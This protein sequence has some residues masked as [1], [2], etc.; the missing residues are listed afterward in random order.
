MYS[1]QVDSNV[2]LDDN[3][4]FEDV[5]LVGATIGHTLDM[6]GS[7]VSGKI[8][9]DSLRV[10]CSCATPSLTKLFW[11]ALKSAGNSISLVRRFMGM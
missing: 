8:D 5:T 4:E 9:L 2:F 10:I 7:K 3:S 11:K 6:S 1:L